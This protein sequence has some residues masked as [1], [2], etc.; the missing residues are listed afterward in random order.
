[1]NDVIELFVEL[2]TFL[3]LFA[4]LILSCVFF[5][6]ILE[7]VAYI[8]MNSDINKMLTGEL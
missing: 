3:S 5:I 6:H 1:M 2:F 4:A 8:A 7:Y